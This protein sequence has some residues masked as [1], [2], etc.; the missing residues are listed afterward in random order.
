M[1]EGGLKRAGVTSSVGKVAASARRK[2]APGTEA[3]RDGTDPLRTRRCDQRRD[4]PCSVVGYGDVVGLHLSQV[5]EADELLTKDPLALLIGMVLDQSVSET[6]SAAPPAFA[7][8]SLAPGPRL[9]A[10]SDDCAPV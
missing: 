10:R 3:R 9:H 8:R 2:Q 1:I 5:D 4:G 7:R 6:W